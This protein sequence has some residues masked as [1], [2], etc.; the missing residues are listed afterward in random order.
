MPRWLVRNN[1]IWAAIGDLL[2]VPGKSRSEHHNTNATSQANGTLHTTAHQSKKKGKGKP[3]NSK[4]AMAGK[5]GS[6]HPTPKR[7]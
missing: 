7:R 6:R 1:Q 2:T 3:S 5:P 4:E